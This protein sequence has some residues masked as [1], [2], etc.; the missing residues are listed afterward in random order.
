M[1]LSGS[2]GLYLFSFCYS[3]TKIQEGEQLEA[4][5]TTYE[6]ISK[7]MFSNMLLSDSFSLYLFSFC[8]FGTKNNV[9]KLKR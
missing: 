5:T 4:K 6:H 3:D 8:D 9:P 2:F 1:L 7:C